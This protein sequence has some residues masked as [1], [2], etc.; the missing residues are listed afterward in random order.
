MTAGNIG[1]LL[2]Y[3]NDTWAAGNNTD[4]TVSSAPGVGIDDEFGRRFNAGTG[5]TISLSG[6]NTIQS[7]GILVTSNA[8]GQTNTIAG[9]TLTSGNGLD[10]IVN[11]YAA[12]GTLTVGSTV[13][14]NG[15]TPIGLTVSG[16]SAFTASVTG[17]NTYTGI[18]TINNATLS[19]NTLATEGTLGGA[20]SSIGQSSN[21]A[22][23]LVL[24]GGTLQY[25]GTGGTTDRLFTLGAGGGTLDASGTG[26]IS[27]S[28]NGTVAFSADAPATLTL[29]GSNAGVNTL[30]PLVGDPDAGHVY[31]TSVVKNGSGTWAVTNANTYT[32]GT[33]INSGAFKAVNTVGSATGTGP[34]TVNATGSIGGSGFVGGPVTV[35]SG[36]N[37]APGDAT[38]FTINSSLKLQAGA[39]GG[40]AFN[41]PNIV[42][43]GGGNDL[44]TVSSGLTINQNFN[45][46]V[47]PGSSFGAGTYTVIHYGNVTDNSSGFTGWNANLQ[48][49]PASLSSG[50]FTLGFQDDTSNKNINLVVTTAGPSPTLPSTTIINNSNVTNNTVVIIQ[51][52]NQGLNNG[53]PNNPAVNIKIPVNNQA[54]GGNAAAGAAAANFGFFI[55]RPAQAAAK[56]F[57]IG[58]VPVV[59]QIAPTTPYYNVTGILPDTAGFENASNPGWAYAGTIPTNPAGGSRRGCRTTGFR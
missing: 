26:A 7:G 31:A 36:G 43:P 28:S 21:G 22:A 56:A 25:V 14:N 15:G 18:T 42:G 44:T 46:N 2:A 58:W 37:L 50:S 5:S 35:N 13:A 54:F 49:V 8:S 41:T 4:V 52:A 29:S 27:Y 19:A 12:G 38:N 32:G 10:L 9:G 24:N 48:S 45:L 57:A 33:T 59:V 30:S 55:Q 23:N 11:G 34:V 53:N 47:T 3:T 20:A 16:V 1:A 39:L 17:A 40:Y 51:Q 6:T